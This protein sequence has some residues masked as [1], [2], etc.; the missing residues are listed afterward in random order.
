MKPVWF[1][2]SNCTYAKDQKEYLPLPAFRNDEG[3]VI[4]CWELSFWERLKL[5]VT[6]KLWLSMLT[7]N[8]P[9][10]PVRLSIE[11]PVGEYKIE[12]GRVI[13]K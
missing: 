4:S 7:F 12:N 10:Q 1:K 5:F 2:E 13:L 9:L 11:K 3:I 6:G 8:H